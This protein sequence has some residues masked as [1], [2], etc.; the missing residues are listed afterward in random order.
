M[1]SSGSASRSALPTLPAP[2]TALPPLT[3]LVTTSQASA[4]G[5][6]PPTSRHSARH[7]R[8]F[9]RPPRIVLPMIFARPAGSAPETLVRA[10]AR[11]SG[12]RS[13]PR[14]IPLALLRAVPVVAADGIRNRRRY[15]VAQYPVLQRIVVAAVDER[16]EPSE[17]RAHV[18]RNDNGP[19]KALRAVDRDDLHSFAVGIQPRLI[20]RLGPKRAAFPIGI[21]VV[22]QRARR[23]ASRAPSIGRDWT[24]P[25]CLVGAPRSEG[26]PHAQAIDRFAQC[27]KWRRSP[28]PA[29]TD[30]RGRLASRAS[31]WRTCSGGVRSVSR[32][33]GHPSSVSSGA[34]P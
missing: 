13:A 3:P 16:L 24:S 5:R 27:E 8:F 25:G 31:A 14:P 7:P 2:N 21:N 30:P 9:G 33:L 32:A 10:L 11:A 1:T 26:G 23:S 17:F 6:A 20:V 29:A 22:R 19:L 28:R 18:D 34:R 15:D 12:G 4:R